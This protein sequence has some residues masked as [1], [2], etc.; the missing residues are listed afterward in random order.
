MSTINFKFHFIVVASIILFFLSSKPVSAED[1]QHRSEPGGKFWIS[2]GFLSYH[3]NRSAHYNER[4]A[5]FGAEYH[6]NDEHAL[7][8]GRYKN[9]VRS[10]TTYAHYVYT[11]FRIWNTR[12]GG[13][14]GLVNGYPMLRDGKFAPVLMPVASTTFR[15]AGVDFG[16]NTVYIPSIIPNVDSAIAVQFKV[17]LY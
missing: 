16:F 6:F 9:S 1:F 15:M 4:N 17:A 14:V 2:T 7:T 11:P 13:A 10:Q 5:G 3:P 8:L 12:L